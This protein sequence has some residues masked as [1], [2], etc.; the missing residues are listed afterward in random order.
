MPAWAREDFVPKEYEGYEKIDK[1]VLE[2]KLRALD[3]KM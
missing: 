1:K 3:E 2:E